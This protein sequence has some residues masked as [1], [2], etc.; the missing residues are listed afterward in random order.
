MTGPRTVPAHRLVPHD[1]VDLDLSTELWG[2]G[3][4][5]HTV[6]GV[7]LVGGRVVLDVGPHRVACDRDT[8]VV[9]VE[10]AT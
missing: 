9:V 6:T 7:R 1:T 2:Q 3:S 5:R 8:P 4:G 10:G